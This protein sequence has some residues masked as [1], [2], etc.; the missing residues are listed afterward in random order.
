MSQ[1][2]AQAHNVMGHSEKKCTNGQG[3]ELS[4]IS[5][6]SVILKLTFRENK[7]LSA[8]KK[9]GGTKNNQAPVLLPQSTHEQSECVHACLPP[10]SVAHCERSFTSVSFM[11][12]QAVTLA[13]SHE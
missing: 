8:E 12:R 10:I 11:Q 2:G 7:N 4:A 1:P 13:G 9:I 6:I 3:W 5:Q